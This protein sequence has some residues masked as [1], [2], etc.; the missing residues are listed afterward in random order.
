[1]MHDTVKILGCHLSYYNQLADERNFVD[2]ISDTQ[3][4]V[5]KKSFSPGHKKIFKAI[6]ASNLIY[7]M[8]WLM[9][10]KDF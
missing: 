4:M 5:I 2:I 3:Q 7:R 10:L 8:V 1:M 6:G 9:F